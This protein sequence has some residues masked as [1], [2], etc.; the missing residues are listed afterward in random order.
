[1][2]WGRSR[3]T[4]QNVTLQRH[5]LMYCTILQQ[6]HPAAMINVLHIAARMEASA[7]C[8]KHSIG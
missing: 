2:S 3:K 4:R 8:I 7:V 1:M 5:P 6:T